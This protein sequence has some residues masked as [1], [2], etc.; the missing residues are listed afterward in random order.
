[1]LSH[2][3]EYG[4]INTFYLW[5]QQDDRAVVGV[6]LVREMIFQDKN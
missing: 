6:M 4:R 1:M 2:E 5:C 3:E